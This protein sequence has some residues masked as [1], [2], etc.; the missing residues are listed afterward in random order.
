MN[1]IMKIFLATTC[2]FICVAAFHHAEKIVTHNYK[3]EMGIGTKYCL[4]MFI[5]ILNRI[6]L[7]GFDFI[8]L[9]MNTNY[10]VFGLTVIF[11]V[12]IEERITIALMRIIEQIKNKRNN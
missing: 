5:Y 6:S 1:N 11:T 10:W 9:L 12:Y 4:F 2:T 8:N 7:A 3:N